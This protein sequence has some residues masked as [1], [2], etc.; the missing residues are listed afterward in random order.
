[1]GEYI[2]RKEKLLFQPVTMPLQSVSNAG[3]VWAYNILS[4]GDGNS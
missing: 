1:M 4:K 3:A 2:K